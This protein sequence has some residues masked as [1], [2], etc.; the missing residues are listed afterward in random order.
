MDSIAKN[1]SEVA[2]VES[3]P[4]FSERKMFMILAPKPVTV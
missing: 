1:L 4:K 2:N 3:P